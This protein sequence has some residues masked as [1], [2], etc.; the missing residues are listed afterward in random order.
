ME[1]Q[2]FTS[3]EN[4]MRQRTNAKDIIVTAKKPKQHPEGYLVRR[5]DNR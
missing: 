3:G 5:Q 2:I 4:Q 1:F